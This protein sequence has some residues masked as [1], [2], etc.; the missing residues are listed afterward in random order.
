ME[1]IVGKDVCI[2]YKGVGSIINWHEIIFLMFFN[3]GLNGNFVHKWY[4]IQIS[5]W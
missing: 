4:M 5:N 1:G 2:F 3:M